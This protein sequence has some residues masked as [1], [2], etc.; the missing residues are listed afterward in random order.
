VIIYLCC[1]LNATTFC[2]EMR[3]QPEYIGPEY[4]GPEYIGP[5]FSGIERRLD[6]LGERLARLQPLRDKSRS[7]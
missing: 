7:Q 6:E 1:A 3:M 4:I 2:E 5:E